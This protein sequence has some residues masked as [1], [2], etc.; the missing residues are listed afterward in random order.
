MTSKRRIKTSLMLP[1][2]ECF[3]QPLCAFAQLQWCD[4]LE[5]AECSQCGRAFSDEEVEQLRK[6]EGG[7]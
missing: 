1:A 3:C 6:S 4:M 5:L 7:I 2:V